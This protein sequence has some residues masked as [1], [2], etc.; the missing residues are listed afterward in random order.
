MCGISRD[1]AINWRDR[2][3]KIHTRK[4]GWGFEKFVNEKGKVLVKVP[5]NYENP[6][7]IKSN[8]WM[9]EHRYI[10]ERHLAECPEKEKYQ[11]YLIDGKYL[12]P[13]HKIHHIN[14]DPSDNRLENLWLC[15]SQSEHK[16]IEYS[17]SAFV[18]ELL[19]SK[20]IV[21]KEGKYDLNF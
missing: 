5:K 21:F 14:F 4:D 8:G 17:L 1:K 3:H 2:V 19:K 15:E 18:D 7:T 13:E 20:H 6:F 9:V 10:M 16:K 12:K 11:K